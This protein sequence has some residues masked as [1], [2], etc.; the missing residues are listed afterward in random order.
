MSQ[1]HGCLIVI[2]QNHTDS[3]S[4]HVDNPPIRACTLPVLRLGVEAALSWFQFPQQ[5]ANNI[6]KKP[7]VH[8]EIE[9]QEDGRQGSGDGPSG[10]G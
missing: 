7:K 8:L 10:L 9:V 4:S 5:D 1:D 2:K 6:E 3:C